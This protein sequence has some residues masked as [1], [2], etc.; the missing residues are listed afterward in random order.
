MSAL[1]QKQTFRYGSVMSALPPK[2][3]IAG[4]DL[5]VRFVPNRRSGFRLSAI[6]AAREAQRYRQY[7]SPKATVHHRPPHRKIRL[8]RKPSGTAL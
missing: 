1:G 3:D 4:R 7:R 2:A 6:T 8:Y 5:D